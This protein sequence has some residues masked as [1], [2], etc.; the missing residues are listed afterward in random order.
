MKIRLTI[1]KART[2]LRIGSHGQEDH[3]LTLVEIL[4]VIAILSLLFTAL[5]PLLSKA[6][7]LALRVVCMNQLRQ[8]GFGLHDYANDNYGKYPVGGYYAYRGQVGNYWNHY[9]YRRRLAKLVDL[10]GFKCV[11]HKWEYIK[12]DGYMD[13]KMLYCPA[14]HDKLQYYEVDSPKS[15]EQAIN[16]AYPPAFL[17]YSSYLY[18]ANET[19]SNPKNPYRPHPTGPGDMTYPEAPVVTDMVSELRVPWTSH[20]DS[21]GGGGNVLYNDGRVEWVPRRRF[22]PG[23]PAIAWTFMWGFVSSHWPELWYPDN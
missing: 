2:R 7:A 12:I 21:G 8:I 10:P 1:F 17:R 16:P 4:V 22:S 23:G 9:V 20:M 5:F 18:W 19:G 11:W 13:Y 3:G 14:S 15:Y 6:R